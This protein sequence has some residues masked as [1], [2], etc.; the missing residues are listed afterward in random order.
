MRRFFISPEQL[1]HPRPFIEGA[2]ARHLRVVLRSQPGD[3]ITVLDGR[4]NAYQARIVSVERERVF[5]DL[6]MPLRSNPDPGTEII[7]AQGYVKDK[8]MDGLV[9][10][11][12]E[13]GIARLIPVQAARSVPV[14]DRKRLL[15]RYER[16]QK[17]SLEAVKQCGR[18]LP[19]IIDPVV[20]FETALN[21]AQSCDTK[22]IFWEK[23]SESQS[24]APARPHPATKVFVMVGPEGGF[25][26]E[27]VELARKAGFSAVGMG[28]RIL[29]A[30]TAALAAAVLTQYLFGDMSQNF[31]DNPQAV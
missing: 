4:G 30:E 3:R 29:R 24:P 16:W 8:K 31:L 22:L 26:P 2:D 7:L 18:R 11:L 17:I 23:K 5:V 14:P 1:A 25:E 28:P 27:E 21:L 13:L 10:P 12:T 9:R 6:E 15:G 19:M 20:P